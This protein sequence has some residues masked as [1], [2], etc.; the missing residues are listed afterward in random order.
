MTRRH[1]LAG[2][3]L[4]LLV[5]SGCAA[6]APERAESV[7]TDSKPDTTTGVTVFGDARIGVAID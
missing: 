1:L 3:F 4:T 6:H 2:T 5:L 7:R